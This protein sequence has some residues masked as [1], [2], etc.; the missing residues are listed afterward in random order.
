[1][2]GREVPGAASGDPERGCGGPQSASGAEGPATVVDRIEPKRGPSALGDAQA[3]QLGESDR[4]GAHAR[5]QAGRDGGPHRERRKLLL[6]RAYDDGSA[7]GPVG[8]DLDVGAVHRGD[9]EPTRSV[10]LERRR[11][12]WERLA[13]P[14]AKPGEPEHGRKPRRA[15]DRERGTRLGR[16]WRDLLVASPCHERVTDRPGF[17]PKRRQQEERSGGVDRGQPYPRVRVR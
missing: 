4:R 5:D 12:A 13:V 11:R 14:T 17:R 8:L 3:T 9:G 15:A 1:M 10:D 7:P 6:A 16:P 2:L